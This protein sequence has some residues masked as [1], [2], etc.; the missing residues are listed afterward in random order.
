MPHRQQLAID[1]AIMEQRI[2]DG[3]GYLQRMAE[4]L[5]RM[6]KRGEDATEVQKAMAEMQVTQ[7]AF[8][9]KRDELSRPVESAGPSI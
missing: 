3:E 1:L 7:Q 9:D 8:V 2:K 6:R 5:E 4:L